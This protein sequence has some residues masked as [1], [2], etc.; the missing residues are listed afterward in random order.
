MVVSVWKSDHF[1]QSYSRF[2]ETN[3]KMTISQPKTWPIFNLTPPFERSWRPLSIYGQTLKFPKHTLT[4]TYQAAYILNF[5][6][7]KKYLSYCQALISLKQWANYMWNIQ[8]VFVFGQTTQGWTEQKAEKRTLKPI[9]TISMIRNVI[10]KPKMD[11]WFN[12]VIPHDK[13]TSGNMWDWL[14]FWWVSLWQK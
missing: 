12:R 8:K 3:R 6:N 11:S 4:S 13:L 14:A 7:R 5:I 10:Q 9:C 2:C 1:W